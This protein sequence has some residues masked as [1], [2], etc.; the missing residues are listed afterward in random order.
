MQD[1]RVPRI[2]LLLMSMSVRGFVTGAIVLVFALV[3]LQPAGYAPGSLEGQPKALAAPSDSGSVFVPA[4]FTSFPVTSP[5]ISIHNLSFRPSV[6]TV[7]V[8]SMVRWTELDGL[9]G[10]TRGLHNVVSTTDA[11]VDIPC[12]QPADPCLRYGETFSVVFDTPGSYQYTCDPHSFMRGT[13]VVLPAP[14]TSP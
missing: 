11:W 7:T 14:S 4:A 9:P 12:E 10:E 6:V 13:I 2:E 8:G 5:A 3:H 1:I